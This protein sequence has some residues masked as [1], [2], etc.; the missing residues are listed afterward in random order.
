[1]VLCPRSLFSILC[2]NYRKSLYFLFEHSLCYSSN[3]FS[4][5]NFSV[6]ITLRW[7]E[8]VFLQPTTPHTQPRHWIFQAKSALMMQVYRKSL[9]VGVLKTTIGE[10][11]NMQSNDSYRLHDFFRFFHFL[12]ATP[13]ICIGLLKWQHHSSLINEFV[14]CLTCSI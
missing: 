4:F 3:F 8:S 11:L 6:N 12:W 5:S 10:I 13:L 1:M 2:S 9:R 14:L 7:D